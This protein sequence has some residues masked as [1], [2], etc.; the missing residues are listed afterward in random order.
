MGISLASR[1]DEPGFLDAQGYTCS[2]WAAFDCHT[3]S[4]LFGYTG[5]E[6]AAILHACQTSCRVDDWTGL[7]LFCASE[8]GD[9]SNNPSHPYALTA[10]EKAQ[11]VMFVYDHVEHIDVRLSLDGR[12][13]FNG[14][15]NFL[16]GGYSNVDECPPPERIDGEWYRRWGDS[17]SV[18]PPAPPPPS[19]PPSAP[20]PSSPPSPPPPAVPPLVDGYTDRLSADDDDT[21]L[22]IFVIVCVLLGLLVLGLLALAYV[23]Y[24]CR[25]ADAPADAK[26]APAGSSTADGEYPAIH[27]RQLDTS[28]V[29]QSDES[30][31]ILDD[32]EDAEAAAEVQAEIDNHASRL[33]DDGPARSKPSTWA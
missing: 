22:P 33:N 25:P 23:L 6:Q 17:P 21:N 9:S 3:A 16:F 8:F 27:R 20:P 19:P 18:P 28:E 30:L 32:V 15:R 24:R 5:P 7:P 29:G 11:S 2:S 4:V 31:D 26:P 1:S 10:L 13:S 12:G 14:G